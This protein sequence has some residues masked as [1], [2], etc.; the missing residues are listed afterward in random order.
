MTLRTGEVHALEIKTANDLNITVK[1]IKY[2]KGHDGMQGINA[3]IYYNN[4][5]F[6]TAYDDAYGGC[7]DVRPI[8]Y[9]LNTLALFKK[10]ED[11]ISDLPEYTHLY[12]NPIGGEP[13]SFTQRITL[14]NIVEAFSYKKEKDKDR[15]K[16]IIYKSGT[17]EHI[18]H[19]NMSIPQMLKKYPKNALSTIQKKYDKLCTEY[20]IVNKDYLEEIGVVTDLV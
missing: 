12:D 13:K 2:F 5:K 9:E 1:N 15:K 7:M 11:L 20:E 6:A 16:G 18:L 8:D 10:V 19:W 14:D 3:D 4:K 17:S